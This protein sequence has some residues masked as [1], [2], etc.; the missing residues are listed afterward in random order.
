MNQNSKSQRELL[1]NIATGAL[2]IAIPAGIAV[3]LSIKAFEAVFPS[4]FFP[5][6][7]LLQVGLYV[8]M[9]VYVEKRSPQ[10]SMQARIGSTVNFF[11]PLFLYIMVDGATVD[12]S[13]IQRYSPFVAWAI[14]VLAIC[15]MSLAKS[16][17]TNP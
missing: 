11:L 14:P 3:G 6:G 17:G 2:W 8:A 1:N 4:W 12:W 9:L 13:S 16:K 15:L 5:S 10:E 7:C